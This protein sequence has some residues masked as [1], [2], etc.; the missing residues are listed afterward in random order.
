MTLS[1]IQQGVA[2]L[3]K[4]D[5][6]LLQSQAEP[7]FENDGD[8]ETKIAYALAALGLMV[9]VLTPSV[10]RN[11]SGAI[12]DGTVSVAVQIAEIPTVNRARSGHCTALD[13]AEHVAAVLDNR[14]IPPAQQPLSFVSL[15][16]VTAT[17]S[18]A[19]TVRFQTRAILT[20]GTAL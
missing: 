10:R 3:L 16:P 6:F 13:M 19:Y 2:A 17:E 15:D 5:A 1:D 9:L 12:I 20:Q 8:L 14:A 7:V 11:G 18:L 4:E